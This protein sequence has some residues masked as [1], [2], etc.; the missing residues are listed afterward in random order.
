M[1][2]GWHQRLNGPSH[3]EALLFAATECAATNYSVPGPRLRIKLATIALANAIPRASSE[4]STRFS[5]FY[6]WRHRDHIAGESPDAEGRYAFPS[7]F[8]ASMACGS[9]V[10]RRLDVTSPQ[11]TGPFIGIFLPVYQWAGCFKEAPIEP[12]LN[13]HIIR[14]AIVAFMMFTKDASTIDNKDQSRSSLR[15]R[16][17]AFGAALKPVNILSVLS[18]NRC[19]TPKRNVQYAS[20]IVPSVPQSECSTLVDF[21]IDDVPIEEADELDFETE[22]YMLEAENSAWANGKYCAASRTK[23]AKYARASQRVL[24][25]LP[26]T[27][28]LI[29]AEHSAWVTSVANGAQTATKSRTRFFSTSCT[30]KATSGIE[31]S[32]S[33][34]WFRQ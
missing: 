1:S 4:I 21:A 23:K 28:Q 8:Y 33:S 12:N 10:F 20:A 24:V 26:E 32:C 34:A 11:G 3:E 29:D 18:L 22:E 13:L 27:T 31:A 6:F 15:S 19:T 14:S 9:A 30:N 2:G 16:V 5:Q 17:S 25:T 7:Q